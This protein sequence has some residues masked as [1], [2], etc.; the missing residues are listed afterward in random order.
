MTIIP[1]VAR[2]RP[3]IEAIAGWRRLHDSQ[4]KD[5]CEPRIDF[6]PSVDFRKIEASG[7]NC[8]GR[9]NCAAFFFGAFWALTKGLWL[10]AVI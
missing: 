4:S 5:G 7:G 1:L 8:K 10:P 6:A 2:N 3:L 9:W